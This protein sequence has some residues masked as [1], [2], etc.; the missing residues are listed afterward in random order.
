[1]IL[2]ATKVL[3]YFDTNFNAH[4]CEIYCYNL[5]N[6]PRY[7]YV[8]CLNCKHR[9]DEMSI[10]YCRCECHNFEEME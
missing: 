9:G 2:K 5:D 7:W 3:G 6:K 1:M 4:G 10:A 8:R